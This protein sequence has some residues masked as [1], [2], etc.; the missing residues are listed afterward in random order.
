MKFAD[1]AEMVRNR[2]PKAVVSVVSDA[3]DPWIETT[4]SSLVALCQFLRDEEP[5]RFDMLH[6]VSAVDE[7]TP[8]KP[9]K[10]N[11]KTGEILAPGDDPNRPDPGFTVV[12]HMSSLANQHTLVVKVRVPRW[13]NA[14]GPKNDTNLP[15]LPSVSGIW[16]AANWHERE[17][18]DLSGVTFTDHPDLR[19]ILCADD[20]V[21]HPLRKDYA[22]PKAYHGIEH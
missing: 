13:Q 14:K 17:V 7:W 6:L 2:L 8:L 5:L 4:S 3:V 12:Y 10:K 18:Y 21:G 15:A 19:R 11:P 22:E 20:W 1:I 9:P 16:P